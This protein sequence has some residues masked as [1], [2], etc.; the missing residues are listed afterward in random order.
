VSGQRD[1]AGSCFV[2]NDHFL[3]SGVFCEEDVRQAE[4]LWNEPQ[5][6]RITARAYS[7]Y[8]FPGFVGNR[9]ESSDSQVEDEIQRL[10]ED[11]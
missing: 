4:G 6:G 3:P 11:I 5:D 10:K 8:R 9:S 7:V 1:S 2:K